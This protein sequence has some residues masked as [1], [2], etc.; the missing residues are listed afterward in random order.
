MLFAEAS[1]VNAGPHPQFPIGLKRKAICLKRQ[2]DFS[3]FDYDTRAQKKPRRARRGSR[4]FS[5]DYLIAIQVV[6]VVDVV[7][8]STPLK[9][10]GLLARPWR[11]AVLLGRDVSAPD[12]RLIRLRHRRGGQNCRKT[13]TD[14]DFF[15]QRMSPF[16]Q[17]TGENV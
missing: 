3:E 14:H 6:A 17:P 1:C 12:L 2:I 16:R 10:E 11:V 4:F 13:R 8:R 15:Q 9:C 5:L 7:V